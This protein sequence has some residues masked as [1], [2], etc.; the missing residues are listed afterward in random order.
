[1]ETLY[2]LIGK[3]RSG[4]V[5]D[6]IYSPRVSVSGKPDTRSIEYFK[7]KDLSRSAVKPNILN[8]I[9][10]WPDEILTFLE[11]LRVAYLD[12][13]GTY[14]ST[15]DIFD[16]PIRTAIFFMNQKKYNQLPAIKKYLS[17]P[18]YG[19]IPDNYLMYMIRESNCYMGS[20]DDRTRAAGDEK[21]HLLAGALNTLLTKSPISDGDAVLKPE[22]ETLL[23][24]YSVFYS[25]KN[26]YAMTDDMLRSLLNE[27]VNGEAIALSLPDYFNDT[28]GDITVRLFVH[29]DR[30]KDDKIFNKVYTFRDLISYALYSTKMFQYTY[31]GTSRTNKDMTPFPNDKTFSRAVLDRLRYVYK[32]FLDVVDEHNIKAQII[33]DKADFEGAMRELDKRKVDQRQ[34]TY[35][36][37]TEDVPE[38]KD[39]SLGTFVIVDSRRP[40]L[41]HTRK[42][43]VAT[44]SHRS[45]REDV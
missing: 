17:S 39:N 31:T 5:K 14:V 26:M 24:T 15:A 4:S 36:R 34:P 29:L 32:Y 42:N 23:R 9:L 2:N 6:A 10:W 28:L 1:M 19:G 27:Y 18:Y 13:D 25:L 20:V 40:T 41:K 45:K 33:A 7:T 12:L 3:R 37:V 30:I 44:F 38:A 35:I 16:T 21:Y 11:V 8:S 22:Y 43:S